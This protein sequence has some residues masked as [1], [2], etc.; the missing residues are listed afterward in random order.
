MSDSVKID[1]GE[2]G[3]RTPSLTVKLLLNIGVYNINK[4]PVTFS[5]VGVKVRPILIYAYLHTLLQMMHPDLPGYVLGTTEVSDLY[6]PRGGYTHVRVP[7]NIFYNSTFD[8]QAMLPLDLIRSCTVRSR[9]TSVVKRCLRFDSFRQ[10]KRRP[11]LS[12]ALI[13]YWNRRGN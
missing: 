11:R 10:I 7:M 1:I 3:V 5:H 9:Y 12:C 8:P 13:S 2:K 4:I 6:V